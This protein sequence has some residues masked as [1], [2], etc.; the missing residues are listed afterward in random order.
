M[1]RE[2]LKNMFDEMDAATNTGQV[3]SVEQILMAANQ[4][5]VE[6]PET[7][8]ALSVE[9]SEEKT[10]KVPVVILSGLLA[11]TS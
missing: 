2:E 5:T 4:G 9:Y 10:D 11:A 3:K 8:E 6:A 7:G 1:T